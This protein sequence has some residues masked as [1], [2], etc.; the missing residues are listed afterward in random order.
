MR[1]SAILAAAAALVFS[2]TI[3]AQQRMPRECRHEIATLCGT[4]RG[5]LRACLRERIGELSAMCRAS[6]QHRMRARQQDSRQPDRAD[7]TIA[8]GSDHRQAI[9]YF[10]PKGDSQTPALILFVHGGGWALGDRDQAIHHK[11]KHFTAAGYAFASAGY[12][13]LPDAPVEMQA[14]DIGAALGAIRRQATEHGFDAH[15]IILMGHSAGAHLAALVATAPE[16]SAAEDFSA[17]AGV[18]L[19]DGAGYDVPANMAARLRPVA[20]IYDRAFGSDPARQAALSPITHTAAPNAP[21]WLVLYV[22]D[23]A[24]SREQSTW[25]AS[26]LTKAGAQAQ[27][28][29]ITG[30]DHGRLN[31]N[32]GVADDVATGHVD[33]FLSELAKAP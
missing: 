2:A 30:T 28:I 29:A 13:L 18:I 4:D 1:M 15:R 24:Q 3:V 22:A 9:S 14:R 17:I 19:L 5:Q 26:A 33:Q 25:L 31:R 7:A 20:S 6:L 12:R 16:Y 8:Y 10:A 27:A 23:R 32:L 21:E 11:A